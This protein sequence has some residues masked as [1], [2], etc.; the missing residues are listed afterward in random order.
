VLLGVVTLSPA[1]A[2]ASVASCVE[3][4]SKGQAE[5]NAGHLQNAR[6]QFLACTAEEC[7]GAI[8]SECSTL[9]TEVEGFMASVV[10]AAVGSDGK[11]AVDVK[12][13]V[14]G[15]Q[16]MDQLSG[17]ATNLDPGSHEV[18]Y[19]W[20]DGFEQKDTIVVAQG[21][22]NR[23]VEMRRAPTVTEKLDTKPAAP[24][25]PRKAPVAAWVVG[26]LGVAALGSF[27][28]FAVLGK[29]AE[30]AMDGCK[31]YCEQS[32][33]DK[34]RLRYLIADISLGV[35]VAA[36]GVSSFLFVRASRSPAHSPS[37]AELR[38]VTVGMR[39]S[40]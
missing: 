37:E 33:A 10:F 20:P 2:H 12:V 11:D 14:D 9:L 19:T 38:S 13:T 3:A 36:I 27:A 16:V 32:Q 29:S 34:M 31:P 35:G 26:G 1:V 18:T 7:P 40:F 22:K 28:T 21:E 23:R 24:P 5:R 15:E 17:L 25:P 39:G 6:A 8:Q 30:H 4:H